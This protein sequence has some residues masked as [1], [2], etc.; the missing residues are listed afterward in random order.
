MSSILT[1][2]TCFVFQP[3]LHA[4][5]NI[6]AVLK[7]FECPVRYKKNYARSDFWRQAITISL[8]L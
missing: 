1:S 7:V 4:I 3:A 8:Y 2:Q 6:P 5:H